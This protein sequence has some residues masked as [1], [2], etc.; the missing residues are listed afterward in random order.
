MTHS[1]PSV[2]TLSVGMPRALSQLVK[3]LCSLPKG[4]VTSQKPTHIPTVYNISGVICRSEPLEGKKHLCTTGVHVSYLC[5]KSQA[6]SQN[7]YLLILSVY[8]GVR[9]QLQPQCLFVIHTSFCT[10]SALQK[11]CLNSSSFIMLQ[12]QTLI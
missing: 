5:C 10:Y 7:Y 6:T 11:Y 8:V 12:P 1:D 2:H 9:I 3:S 4:V